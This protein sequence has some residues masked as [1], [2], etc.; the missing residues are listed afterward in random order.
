MKK[1][2]EPNKPMSV[3]KTRHDKLNVVGYSLN[4]FK[5]LF[6]IYVNP[7]DL[8]KTTITAVHNITL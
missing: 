5:I 3:N 4:R 8:I 1:I 6:D 2:T 7:I